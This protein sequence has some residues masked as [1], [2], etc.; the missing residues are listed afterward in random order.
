MQV[1]GFFPGDGFVNALYKNPGHGNRWLSIKLVGT[2]SN[3]AAIGA[4]IEVKVVD[5]DGSLRSVH[6]TVSNGSSFGSSTLTQEI[7][8]GQAQ[9][10]VSLEVYW[11][12]SGVR[13]TFDDVPL[14]RH[15]RIVEGDDSY[16][17]LDLAPLPLGIGR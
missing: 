4:Q 5:G 16:E 9:N 10:L 3:R 11:P 7:G 12:M 1:G 14:D 13:Q 2:E 6:S 8:L 17:V 15:L